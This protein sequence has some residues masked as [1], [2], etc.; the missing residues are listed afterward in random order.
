MKTSKAIIVAVLAIFC[1]AM[2]TGVAMAEEKVSIKGKI[3]SI[4]VDAKT[5]VWLQKMERI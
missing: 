3:K 5:A 2:L 1:M 4:N